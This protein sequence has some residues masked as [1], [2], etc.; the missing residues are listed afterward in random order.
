MDNET[1]STSELKAR[2]S[3][4]MRDVVSKRSSVIV[5]L[6]GRP[7]AKIVP[8]D[9]TPASLFGYAKGS[10]KILDDIIE[11]IDVEWEASR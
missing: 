5:T 11:P 8:L 7:I 4:V 10:V 1:I 9:E 3:R 2:C 6:R